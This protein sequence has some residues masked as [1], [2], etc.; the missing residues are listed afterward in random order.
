M[1]KIFGILRSTV[2]HLP[3]TRLELAAMYNIQRWN[4]EKAAPRLAQ[5]YV[6][7]I[8]SSRLSGREHGRAL[9]SWH[10]ALLS[11]RFLNRRQCTKE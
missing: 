8:D 4:R 2:E 6:A 7:L 5:A 10:V 1:E 11:T 3:P 9:A